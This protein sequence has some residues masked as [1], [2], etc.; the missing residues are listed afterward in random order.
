MMPTVCVRGC[1]D[2]ERA[3]V[4]AGKE[5][6]TSSSAHHRITALSAAWSRRIRL[7]TGYAGHEAH[8]GED[9]SREDGNGS[10]GG[11]GERCRAAHSARKSV[12][13]SEHRRA[14]LRL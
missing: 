8:P 1:S 5:R 10:D 7:I 4:V 3:L 2:N 11:H 9:L 14:P 13:S 12:L 6:Y